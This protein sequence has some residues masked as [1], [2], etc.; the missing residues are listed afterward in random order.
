M[1]GCPDGGEKRPT[2][3]QASAQLS[4]GNSKHTAE[5]YTQGLFLFQADC[6]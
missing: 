3:T 6:K 1:G 4:A 2:A 5:E